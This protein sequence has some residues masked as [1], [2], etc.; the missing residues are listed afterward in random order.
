VEA[1]AM[2]SARNRGAAG[3]LPAPA[4]C[5]GDERIVPSP[6]NDTWLAAV[7]PMRRQVEKPSSRTTSAA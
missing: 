6:R 7:R 2:G 3:G 5:A 1:T 4:G